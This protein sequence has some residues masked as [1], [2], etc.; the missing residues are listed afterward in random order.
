MSNPTDK[1]LDSAVDT[2]KQFVKEGDVIP[3]EFKLLC[4][5]FRNKVP[6]AWHRKVNNFLVIKTKF[7][8]GNMTNFKP[9]FKV[10]T[11]ITW[12]GSKFFS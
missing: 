11:F 8:S 9:L 12:T 10:K 7:V 3:L 6:R 5:P 1:Y 2:Y 4:G